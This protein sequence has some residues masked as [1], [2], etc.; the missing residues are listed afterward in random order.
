M[1]TFTILKGNTFCFREKMSLPYIVGYLFEFLLCLNWHC[2]VKSSPVGCRAGV[3]RWAIGHALSGVDYEAVE[4][5][6]VDFGAKLSTDAAPALEFVGARR[7]VG[8]AAPFMV[9]MQTCSTCCVTARDCAAAQTLR[10]AALTIS[11]ANSPCT[12]LWAVCG[13]TERKRKKECGIIQR[14]MMLFLFFHCSPQP[15]SQL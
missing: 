11:C 4:L 9:V 2:R 13:G 15:C 1:G 12:L 7:A 8:H 3:S 14:Q 10:V 6:E 5:R